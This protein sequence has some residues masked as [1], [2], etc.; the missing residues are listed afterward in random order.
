MCP[1]HAKNEKKQRR[2]RRR[3]QRRKANNSTPIHKYNSH[4]ETN[5]KNYTKREQ[6]QQMYFSLEVLSK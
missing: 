5:Q 1:L 2:R 3:H 6:K 4:L